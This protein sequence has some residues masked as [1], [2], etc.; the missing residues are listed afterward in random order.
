MAQAVDGRMPVGA[1]AGVMLGVLL[2]LAAAAAL[3]TLHKRRSA[4]ADAACQ[5]RQATV[6]I[7]TDQVTDAGGWAP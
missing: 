2:L 6:D 7:K 3:C 5:V 1:I 4:I